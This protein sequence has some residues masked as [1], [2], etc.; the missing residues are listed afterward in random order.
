VLKNGLMMSLA[1]WIQY[2]SMIDGQTDRQTPDDGLYRA[3]ALRAVK[4]L[5]I[6]GPLYL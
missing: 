1:V 2:T 3:Y 6:F 4:L 5:V